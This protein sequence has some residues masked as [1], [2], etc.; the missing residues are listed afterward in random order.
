MAEKLG[1]K[2]MARLKHFDSTTRDWN[3]ADYV[4]R[5]DAVRDL[6]ALKLENAMLKGIDRGRDA[7]AEVK[8]DNFRLQA[9]LVKAEARISEL[10]TA[11]SLFLAVDPN[12]PILSGRAEEMMFRKV[13]NLRREDKERISGL[14]AAIKTIAGGTLPD[15][16]GVNLPTMVYAEAVLDG[17]THEEMPK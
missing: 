15:G 3:T 6:E 1:D 11:L 9:A 7:W 17:R 10:E 13:E 12:D 16:D 5:D 2:A 14:E 8:V 4:S